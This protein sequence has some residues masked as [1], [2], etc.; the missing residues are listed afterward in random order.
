METRVQKKL[1]SCRKCFVYI[2]DRSKHS[3]Y[4]DLR[5]KNLCYLKTSS[6]MA[7]FWGSLINVDIKGNESNMLLARFHWVV[8]YGSLYKQQVH[9]RRA[10]GAD[11]DRRLHCRGYLQMSF[12]LCLLVVG[13]CIMGCWSLLC[14]LLR[15]TIK[16]YSLTKWHFSSLQ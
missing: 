6:N 13:N 10:R 9:L 8:W 7:I 2:R 14:P 5:C 3:Q 15:L 1:E 4:E 12:V 16:P 11:A